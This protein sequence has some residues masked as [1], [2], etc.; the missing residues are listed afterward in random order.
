MK[1]ESQSSV[2]PSQAHY[3]L[4]KL[5]SEKR[6]SPREVASYLTQMDSEISDLEARLAILREARSHSAAP[7][8]P[9]RTRKPRPAVTPRVEATASEPAPRRGRAKGK[10]RRSRKASPKA[11]AEVAGSQKIQGTYLS[12]IRQISK[13][14]RSVFQQVA[15]QQGRE[16]AIKQMRTALKK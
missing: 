5:L 11:N 15:L 1:V 12:L 10:R 14:K 16:E 2:S 8:L 13:E 7:T 3:I 4:S 9:V 6:V